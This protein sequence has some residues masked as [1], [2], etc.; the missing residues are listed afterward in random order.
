MHV[1]A[2]FGSLVG[3]AGV[4]AW[5]VRETRRAVTARSIV[6]PPLAMST[7]FLMFVVP[8]ARPAWPL[9]IGALL[10]G[11]L[12]FSY[13]LIHT[14]ALEVEGEAVMMR[15][16]KAFLWILLGLVAVRLALRSYVEHIVSPMQTAGMFFLLAFGMIVPWRVVM[17]ARYRALIAGQGN[18][19]GKAEAGS[20]KVG[21]AGG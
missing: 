3:A 16:S 9:A 17:Y 6:I 18:A 15:R 7:G 4:V 19:Q 11:A 2:A 12:L 13:P 10:A 8:Q 20:R 5:R 1:V 21:R 14:S